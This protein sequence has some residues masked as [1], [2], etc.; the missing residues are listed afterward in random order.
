[1]RERG[2]FCKMTQKPC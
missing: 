2:H 1:M